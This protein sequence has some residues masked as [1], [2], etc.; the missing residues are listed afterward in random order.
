MIYSSNTD[1][2]IQREYD[3]ELNTVNFDGAMLGHPRLSI[4][5]AKNEKN[6][7]FRIV[8]SRKMISKIIF[9]K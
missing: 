2:M 4:I 8:F 9:F 3:I 1:R 6:A 7:V 5:T